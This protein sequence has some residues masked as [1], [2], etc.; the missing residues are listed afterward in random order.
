[1]E[2]VINT[3]KQAFNLNPNIDVEKNI[4]RGIFYDAGFTL[5]KLAQFHVPYGENIFWIRNHNNDIV[6]DHGY[7]KLFYAEMNKY[8]GV[9][10]VRFNILAYPNGPRVGYVT[11]I[12]DKIYIEA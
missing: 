5:D 7:W 2:W 3:V 8:D 12:D 1:M 6:F 4:K 10:T 11:I 9:K